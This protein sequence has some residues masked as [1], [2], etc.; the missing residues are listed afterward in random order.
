MRDG[1]LTTYGRPTWVLATTPLVGDGLQ[2]GDLWV[3]LFIPVTKRCTSISPVTF[4]T[5]EGGGGGGGET[6]TA[7]NVGT[8]GTS[9]V[10]GKVG[11][12]LQ[13][14]SVTAA[15]NK[16]TVTNN[17]GNKSVDID[18]AQANLSLGS[19]GG[20]A[21]YSQIQNVSATDKIL[22]RS[23]AGAGV[24]QEITHQV[25]GTDMFITVTPGITCEQTSGSTQQVYVTATRVA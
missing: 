17:A 7:T 11:V 18:V 24:I 22:G 12:D 13:F 21:S 20:S 10:E 6:N 3:D 1:Q 16:L 19:I 4:A 5:V 15:S 2:V 14:R 9:V 8:T 25:N 23:S